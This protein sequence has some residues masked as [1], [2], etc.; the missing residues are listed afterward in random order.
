MGQASD[1]D[2][3]M[4]DPGAFLETFRR[5]ETSGA[6]SRTRTSRSRP[7]GALPRADG[8]PESTPEPRPIISTS[9]TRDGLSARSQLRRG[10]VYVKLPSPP[11][12]R[13]EYVFVKGWDTIKKVLREIHSDEGLFYKVRYGD[14]HSETV[15][16]LE[17]LLE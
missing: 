11:R 5:K 14:N 13:D 6:A 9:S 16:G 8:S 4:Q 10:T 3:L 15:R 2:E 1:S 17:Q 7:N 12:N